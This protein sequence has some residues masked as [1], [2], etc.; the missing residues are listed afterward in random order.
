MQ[1]FQ[2]PVKHSFTETLSSQLNFFPQSQ[3][4]CLNCLVE[5]KR[6]FAISPKPCLQRSDLHPVQSR[7]F[8][9]KCLFSISSGPIW[10][11]SQLE[12][13]LSRTSASTL[14]KPKRWE[15]QVRKWQQAGSQEM[16]TDVQGLSR[17]LPSKG[18]ASPS[19]SLP[20]VSKLPTSNK[21]NFNT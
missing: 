9:H 15:S 14:P 20:E 2:L 12:N 21:N 19:Y 7:H 4:Y 8:H 10:D 5:F 17:T 6:N 11:V 1:V 16:G 18:Q 13:R 3:I